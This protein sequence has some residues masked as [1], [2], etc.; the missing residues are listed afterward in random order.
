MKIDCHTHILNESRL[1]EYLNKHKIDV[2]FCIR[3][4]KGFFGGIFDTTDEEFYSFIENNDNL[5]VIE[6]IDFERN[7]L[8]QLEEIKQ[9]MK[10]SKKIKGIKLYP[11]YQHFYPNHERLY[12]VYNFAKENNIVVVF[13]SGALYGDEYQGALLK[14]TNPIYVDEIAVRFP[15]VKFVVSHFGFPYLLETAMVINKNN[16]VYTDISGIIDGEDVF[17]VFKGDLK[18]VLGYYPDIKHQIMFGT[19]FIGDDTVL[20]EVSLYLKLVEELFSPEEQ[21][22][23]FYRNASRVYSI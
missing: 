15:T 22:L 20:N 23:V 4:L 17:E 14:Y 19:D 13:H 16:N 10:I 1:K 5:Y 21:E 6:S 3:F 9:K 18:R 11:G 8:E 7:I 12:S 2:V